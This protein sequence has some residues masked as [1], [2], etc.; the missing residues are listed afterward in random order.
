MS[1]SGLSIYPTSCRNGLAD[2]P[3]VTILIPCLNEEQTIGICI[4]KAWGYLNRAG[5]SGEIIIADNG[6]TDD[7]KEIAERLGARVVQIPDRGYGAALR[8]GIAAAHGRYVIMGD[9][10]DSY[11]FSDLSSFVEVLETGADLVMGNRFK[12][13]IDPGAMPA[14]HRYLG[15]PVLSWLG[16][17]LFRVPVGDFHCGL[18]GFRRTSILDLDLK[19]SG[20]EF[21]SEM[22][23]QA[24]LRRLRIEEVPTRLSKDGRGRPPHLNTWRDGWRH[25]RFLMLHSPRWTFAYPG[26]SLLAVGLALVALLIPGQLLIGS[27]GL[28]IRA[29]LIGCLA[30]TVGGQS[31]T[32]ALLARRFA[33]QH[34]LLPATDKLNNILEQITMERLLQI[35]F[36]LG[37]AGCAGVAASV[38]VWGEQGFGPLDQGQMLRVMALSATAITV[39]V[40]LGFSAFLLGVMDLSARRDAR[41]SIAQLHAHFPGVHKVASASKSP[42]Q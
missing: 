13:G 30:I 29:F 33:G 6:S 10:D 36:L 21:A 11:D 34:R 23:V 35:A 1:V 37:A 25:L 7:S 18:R 40:Q 12:G 4:E 14:L 19:T 5:I 38:Y 24:S 20:M 31:L 15:N 9:A 26:L 3:T 17:I 41:D 42:N 27:I 8:G 32:F 39:A 28:D 2:E 22:V 16:R